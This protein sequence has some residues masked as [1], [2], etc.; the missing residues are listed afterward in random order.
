MK[1]IFNTIG[2]IFFL[3]A[4]IFFIVVAIVGTTITLGKIN[5]F[6]PVPEKAKSLLGLVVIF[7]TLTTWIFTY[8][9]IL[10]S[11]NG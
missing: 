6:Q 4:L 7:I 8:L 1:Y 2:V 11:C 3:P 5:F 10:N 9:I